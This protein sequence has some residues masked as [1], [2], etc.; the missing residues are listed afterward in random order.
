MSKVV[1]SFKA[2]TIFEQ[3]KHKTTV[4]SLN[5]F[6]TIFVVQQFY[7]ANPNYLILKIK[8]KRWIWKILS[9]SLIKFAI[10][11]IMLNFENILIN[12][13]KSLQ[14]N[15]NIMKAKAI[16]RLPLLCTQTTSLS[17]NLFFFVIF[18]RELGFFKKKIHEFNL[19]VDFRRPGY[20][21]IINFILVI[22]KSGAF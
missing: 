2:N 21:L 4:C 17:N 6:L 7:S 19:F 1:N 8:S 22:F 11:S 5:S 13:A 10:I 3:P 14:T 9:A 15:S 16:R 12:V 20:R 18:F